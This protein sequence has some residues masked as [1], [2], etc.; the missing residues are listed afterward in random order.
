[1][2]YY[3]I[4]NERKGSNYISKGTVNTI[5]VESNSDPK[6]PWIMIVNGTTRLSRSIYDV[7]EYTKWLQRTYPTINWETKWKL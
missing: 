4:I 7:Q 6:N 2:P 5:V 1:M 3:T